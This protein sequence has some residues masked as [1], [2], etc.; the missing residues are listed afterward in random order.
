MRRLEV[1][2]F[3]V[4]DLRDA[5]ACDVQQSQQDLVASPGLERQHGVDVGLG[6]DP[7]GELVFALLQLDRSA[8]LERQVAGALGEWRA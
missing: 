2:P 7:L 3:Q 5:H 4:D 8:D 6:Q 1:T